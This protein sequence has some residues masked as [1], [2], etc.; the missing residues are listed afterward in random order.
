MAKRS[1]KATGTAFESAVVAY[2]RAN[3]FP[4]AERAA[5]AGA[6]DRGDIT[7]C[8][9]VVWE[10]K[11]GRAAKQASDLQVTRWLAETAR[12]KVN[13]GAEVGVL[14]LDRA[15]YGAGRTGRVWAVVRASDMPSWMGVYTP[16]VECRVHLED[17]VNALRAAGFGDPDV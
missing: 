7:G 16:A 10:C 8:P 14:V 13:A 1:P 3:G 4:Y 15:G 2:L 11:G 6:N 17:M 5:L 12:E 9:G